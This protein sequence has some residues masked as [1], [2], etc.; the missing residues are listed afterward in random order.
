MALSPSIETYHLT[1][2]ASEH[3]ERVSRWVRDEKELFWLAPKT[4]PPLTAVKVI[5]WTRERGQGYLFFRD[6]RRAPRGYFELNPMP[7]SETHLWVGHCVIDPRWRGVGL[8]LRML[9]LMLRQAFDD[10]RAARLSLVVFPDNRQ[11]IRCYRR[12]G[13]SDAGQQLQCF[14]EDGAQHVMRCM[15]IKREVY[16]RLARPALDT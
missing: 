11:A 12:G 6:G 7:N 2:F 15:T 1:A 16:T 10:H 5:D 3:A 13:F 9:Q 4:P 14:S 8:G